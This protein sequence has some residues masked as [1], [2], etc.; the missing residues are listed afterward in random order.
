MKKNSPRP[1]PTLVSTSPKTVDSG[2]KTAFNPHD[3]HESNFMPGT[4]SASNDNEVI[5]TGDIKA[6]FNSLKMAACQEAILNEWANVQVPES[7]EA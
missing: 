2:T 5:T 4:R 7:S 1:P 6:H 3:T